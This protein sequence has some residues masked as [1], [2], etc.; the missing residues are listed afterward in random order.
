VDQDDC[1]TV[2]PAFKAYN[3]GGIVALLDPGYYIA[4][5]LG[6]TLLNS[7]DFVIR[8]ET[9]LSPDV[10]FWFSNSVRFGVSPLFWQIGGRDINIY[11]NGVINA[12]DK[13]GGMYYQL[14]PLL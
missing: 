5:L 11:G 3:D 1:D 14:M 7:V 8:G 10:E 9:W 13:P 12:M 6:L 4:E 2:F